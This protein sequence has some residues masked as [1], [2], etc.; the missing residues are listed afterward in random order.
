MV[1]TMFKNEIKLQH[2][3][4]Q[5]QEQRKDMSKDRDTDRRRVRN[6]SRAETWARKDTKAETRLLTVSRK[7][8]ALTSCKFDKSAGN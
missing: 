4:Q 2:S 1:P 3:K 5:H 7:I 6:W 8:Q